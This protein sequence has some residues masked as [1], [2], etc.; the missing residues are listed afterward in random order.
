MYNFR[1]T[2][3]KKIWY[4]F[5]LC[6]ISL[7]ALAS[8]SAR[9]E[10][11][12]P[13]DKFSITTAEVA[14]I[15]SFIK[16]FDTSKFILNRV[17]V[18]GHTDQIGSNEYNR[19]LSLKRANT[20]AD[21]LKNKGVNA[22][23]IKDINGFGKQQLVTNILDE[24]KRV[25]N[26][27]VEIQLLFEVKVIPPVAVIKETLKTITINKA[28]TKIAEKKLAD[29]FKD[30]SLKVGDNIELPYILFRGGL[31]E[32]LRISY[33]YLD[34]LVALMKN[35]LKL[36][37]EIQGHICCQPG[38]GDGVDNGTGKNNLSVARAKAVYDFLKDAGIV[39]SRMSYKGY[40]HQFPLTAERNYAE[41]TR[42]RRVEIK[43]L[44]K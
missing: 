7:F 27:R 13:S 21:L 24:N 3:L 35:N 44:S 25:F 37:I 38:A 4:S 36:K 19:I 33:P 17:S 43:I 34:E 28:E 8:D 39:K 26:R 2:I 11:Y 31:H 40:G 5:I 29:I 18:Y 32:F 22:D 15:D 10:V 12:F 14:K 6:F 1:Y 9:L 20:V 42:N 41:E 16:A 23:L 30:T